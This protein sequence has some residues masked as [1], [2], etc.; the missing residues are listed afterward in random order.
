MPRKTPIAGKGE[1][2]R[3]KIVEAAAAMFNQKGFEGASL[4]ELMTATGLEKGGIYRHFT[5]KEELAAEAFD[6]TWA[7][8]RELRMQGIAEEKTGLGKI[9]RY[10]ANFVAYRSPVPGGCCILNTAVDADDGNPILRDRVTK[11]LEGWISRL[12]TYLRLAAKQGEL[13]PG[14]D[15][16]AV[17]TM[18]IATLEGAL[19][20]SR[21]EKSDRALKGVEKYLYSWL[22]REVA[23]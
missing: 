16:K 20:M 11:A 10:I 2:T 7:V 13:R 22:D 23:A 3:Q 5:G 19:M 9:R 6:Y 17:A 14:V 12:Q 4:G 8:A 1:Q 15:T 18:V 21:L